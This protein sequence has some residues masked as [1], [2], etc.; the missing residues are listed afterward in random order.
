MDSIQWGAHPLLVSLSAMCWLARNWGNSPLFAWTKQLRWKGMVKSEISK[1]GK[2]HSA[3]QSSLHHTG[4]K[5]WGFCG[6]TGLQSPWGW[7]SCQ[8]EA[9]HHNTNSFFNSLSTSLLSTS[10]PFYSAEL[11]GHRSSA[12]RKGGKK[13]QIRILLLWCHVSLQLPEE[14]KWGGMCWA[15]TPGIQWQIWEW[16]KAAPREV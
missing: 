13:T 4:T 7:E 8:V 10:G 9:D 16:L 11:Y 1:S 12:S 3:I 6:M 5:L 2:H 15:L 14:E